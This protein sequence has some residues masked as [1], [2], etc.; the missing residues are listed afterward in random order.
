MPATYAL[1]DRSDL[2]LLVLDGRRCFIVHVPRM[3]LEAF[4]FFLRQLDLF[5]PAIVY[6]EVASEDVDNTPVVVPD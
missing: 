6:S 5:K 2:P 3:S 4:E 1:S